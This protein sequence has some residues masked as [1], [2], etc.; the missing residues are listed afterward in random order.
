RP[1]RAAAAAAPL[2]CRVERDQ[3]FI[4]RVGED[5]MQGATPG[6]HTGHGVARGLLFALPSF[7]VTAADTG[8]RPVLKRW[9]QVLLDVAAIVLHSRRRQVLGGVPP[10]GVDPE[11]HLPTGGV[12]PAAGPHLRLLGVGGLLCLP[13]GAEADGYA[14]VVAD[15]AVPAWADLVAA[16]PVGPAVLCVSQGMALLCIPYAASRGRRGGRAR[17]STTGRTGC[18]TGR[19]FR[20]V[21]TS[22]SRCWLGR[23]SKI[24]MISYT[25][26]VVN[27]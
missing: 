12:P 1:A 4:H 14:G 11:G 15:G 18:T 27:R 10:R 8:Q 17:S 23:C 6:L 16:A 19:R 3:P 20:P 2:G 24:R 25:C 22:G 13:L 7:H 5:Q 9:Q 21:V 26:S